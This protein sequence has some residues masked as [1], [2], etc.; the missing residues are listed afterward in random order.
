MAYTYTP[1]N[2]DPNGIVR[3]SSRLRGETAWAPFAAAGRAV[4]GWFS[5]T[6]RTVVAFFRPH[7]A[8]PTQQAIAE[9]RA[10]NDNELADLGI[11]RGQIVDAVL[12]GRIG[13]ER[14][15]A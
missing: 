11:G 5:K 13:I 7:R 3:Q 2:T 8:T 9:L 6:C 4:A 10:Y 14:P 15:A 12:H 1:R